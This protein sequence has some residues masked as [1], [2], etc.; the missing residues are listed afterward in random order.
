MLVSTHTPQ[1]RV[2]CVSNKCHSNNM[3]TVTL[4][5]KQAEF[6]L[7]TPLLRQIL[8]PTAKY[9]TALSGYR[10]IGLKLDDLIWEENPAMQKAISRLPAEESYARNFRIMTAHQLTLSHDLLPESKRVKVEDDVPYLTPYII[11]AEAEIAE[12]AALND[13]IVAK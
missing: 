11:E 10:N 2:D 5:K 3:S 13:S 6:V 4:V 7:K 1:A 9:F 8:L 12:K